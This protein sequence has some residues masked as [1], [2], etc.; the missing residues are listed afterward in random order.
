MGPVL[1][2]NAERLL[3]A[4]YFAI[5]DNRGEARLLVPVIT[6]GSA[7]KILETIARWQGSRRRL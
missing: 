3:S 5:V 6:D 2:R 4:N 1:R 7:T